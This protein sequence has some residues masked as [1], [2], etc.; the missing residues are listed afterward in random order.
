[1]NFAEEILKKI[2]ASKKYASQHP[3]IPIISEKI[4]R[5]NAFINAYIDWCN[6]GK[7][8]NILLQIRKDFN[9][10]I[11]QNKKIKGLSIL[12][13]PY[14][15]GIIL[16]K[17]YRIKEK[18]LIYLFDYF[19]EAC[20]K[21]AYTLYV[22]DRKITEENNSIKTK[23][24]H[25]LKPKLNYSEPPLSQLYGNVIIELVY[26][27]NEFEYLK[28]MTNKYS[29]RLYQNPLPFEDLMEKIFVPL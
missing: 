7:R 6:S 21:N 23:D 13:S 4:D 14:A 10:S 22:S 5:S 19:K 24:K 3:S 29:D 17:N 12:I 2:F 16:H 18:E 1:M 15:D 26:T 20:I 25:Y 11:T 27:N 9:E 28:F 8:N